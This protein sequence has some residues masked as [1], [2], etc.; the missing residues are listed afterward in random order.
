MEKKINLI[1]SEEKA[2]QD[3][4]KLQKRFKNLAIFLTVAFT[5]VSL[6]VFITFSN[7]NSQLKNL[8][9]KISQTEIDIKSQSQK[10]GYLLVLKDRLAVIDQILSSRAG[11]AQILLDLQSLSPEGVRFDIIDTSTS[12]NLRVTA[13]AYNLLTL[14]E[15]VEKVSDQNFKKSFSFFGMSSI[16]KLE[17]GSYTF[18]MEMVKK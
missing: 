10:E 18:I 1:P 9:S 12:K 7:F 17:N 6:A 2:D 14:N 4:A 16:A 5:G 15:L 8:S 11:V 3:L 13:S